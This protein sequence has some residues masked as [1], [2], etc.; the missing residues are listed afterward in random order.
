MEIILI[1]LTSAIISAFTLLVYWVG[2]QEGKKSHKDGY[3]PQT[4]EQKEALRDLAQWLNW[5]GKE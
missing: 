4:P 1:I 5:G 3:T 2:Y